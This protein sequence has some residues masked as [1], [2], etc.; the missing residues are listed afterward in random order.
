MFQSCIENLSAQIL[1][2]RTIPTSAATALSGVSFLLCLFP[3]FLG[4]CPG[5][6]EIGCRPLCPSFK[7]YGFSRA[8]GNS[9]LI[10][11]AASLAVKLSRIERV[12]TLR[13]AAGLGF[14][15]KLS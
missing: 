8:Q 5:Y 3:Q 9:G 15:Q 2:G 4:R 12:V 10:L 6:V 14:S 13:S 11:L 1:I 7:C